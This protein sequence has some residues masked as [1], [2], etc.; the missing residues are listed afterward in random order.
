[1]NAKKDAASQKPFV[2][3]VMK[4]LDNK[5]SAIFWTVVSRSI[6]KHSKEASK[7]KL[8]H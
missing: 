6:E 1:M 7:S 3:E 8:A 2:D 5:P 4:V